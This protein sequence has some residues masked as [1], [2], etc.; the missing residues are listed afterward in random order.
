MCR[1]LSNLVATTFINNP[2]KY[3][4]VEH[5]DKN[6]KNNKVENLRWVKNKWNHKKKLRIQ[7]MKNGK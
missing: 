6:I 2:E 5:I 1:T 3:R 4:F 7:K